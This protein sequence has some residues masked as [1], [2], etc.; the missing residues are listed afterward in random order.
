M[1]TVDMIQVQLS[2]TT[3]QRQYV[4]STN[5]DAVLTINMILVVYMIV[6]TIPAMILVNVFIALIK[7]L[8]YENVQDNCSISWFFPLNILAPIR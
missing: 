6:Y 3:V 5:V 8:P 4:Q 7:K 2:V 1:M